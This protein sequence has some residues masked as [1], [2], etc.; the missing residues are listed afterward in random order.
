MWGSCAFCL[1][2]HKIKILSLNNLKFI[3]GEKKK[4]NDHTTW[5]L[6]ILVMKTFWE[7]RL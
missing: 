2:Y 5:L 4:S 3:W 1:L 6:A 7:K